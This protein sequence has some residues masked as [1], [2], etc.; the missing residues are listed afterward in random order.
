MGFLLVITMGLPTV[1]PMVIPMGFPM[2]IPMGNPIGIPMGIPMAILIGISMENPMGISMGI[3][4]CIPISRKITV[5]EP[6][7]GFWRNR[8]AAPCLQIPYL[9][10]VRTPKASLVG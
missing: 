1:V 2:G 10:K 8:F 3:P 6:S 4:T 7:G 5:G 9:Q